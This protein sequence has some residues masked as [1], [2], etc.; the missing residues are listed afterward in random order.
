MQLR[1]FHIIS[2]RVALH[3]F[4]YLVYLLQLHIHD[5]IHYALGNGYMLLEELEVEISL[6]SERINHIGIQIY[7]QQSAGV[8][9]TKRYLSAWV[10]RNGTEAKVSIAVRNAL[11]QDS[12]PEQHA[13]LCTLPCVMHNLLP[14][15]FGVYLFLNLGVK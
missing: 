15:L 10:C 1:I 13:R 6:R 7:R 9:R 4:Y 11:S 12:I 2:L 8:I 5:V 14:Q 3:L